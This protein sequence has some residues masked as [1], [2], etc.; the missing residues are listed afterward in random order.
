MTYQELRRLFVRHEETTP[1][2]HLTGYITFSS[3][4]PDASRAYNEHSRTYV[5][6]SDNKAFHP[7]M[8]GYSIFGACL[9]GT[10][11]SVRL[12]RFMAD[13]RGGK[14]GW[15]VEKCCL[16]GY[17][18]AYVN[19]RSQQR[20]QMFYSHTCAA[21]AMLQALCKEGDLEYA[22]IRD[23]YRR[24]QCEYVDDGFGL[25]RNSAWLNARGTGNWDW[26]IWPIRIY[27]PQDII[28]GE[29][30]EATA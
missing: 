13:E 15:T 12:D 14:N 29:I 19:E 10:D 25:T 4:G 6:S 11:S 24:H 16:I 23:I 17:L 28:L 27:A 3:F 21:E 20:P 30:V 1:Q 2:D 22:D 7:N 26:Q 9:D 18:L 5:V 8:G